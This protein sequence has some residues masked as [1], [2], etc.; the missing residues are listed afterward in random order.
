MLTALETGLGLDIVLGLQASSNPLFDVLAWILNIAGSDL[1]YISVLALVYWSFNR[2]LGIRMIF[3]LLVAGILTIVLKELLHRPRPF[4]VSEQVVPLF[5]VDS[6][7]IPSGHVL[8]AVVVWG[9][10]AVHLRR[11]WFY[12]L[13]AVYIVLMGLARIYAGVHY[14]QDVIAG[15]IV[16][17]LLLWLYNMYAGHVATAWQHLNAPLRAGIVV[18]VGVVI[19]IALVH[20]EA[21]LAFAGLMIGIGLALELEARSVRFNA[22][23]TVRQGV[24]R[25][26]PGI[27]LTLLVLLGLRFLFGALVND[28]TAVLRVVRY[29]LTALFAIYAWPWLMLHTGLAEPEASST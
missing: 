14:P 10:L 9:T 19:A 4:M 25:Y 8:M 11:G 27:L 5:E 1:F 22:Q 24:I 2:H 12:G 15:L 6:F 23:S 21:G 13:A 28:E 7:G 16:G 29:A 18:L 17:L 26:L 3:G 20:D